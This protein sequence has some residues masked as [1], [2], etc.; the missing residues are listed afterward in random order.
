MREGF[1]Y[2]FSSVDPVGGAHIDPPSVA[3]YETLM[4]KGPDDAPL[5]GLAT[6]W[7]V[8]ADALTWR[9]ELRES[10]RFH[11]GAPCDAEAVVAALNG[12]RWGGDPDRQLWYWDPVD[13]VRVVG[14]ATVDITLHHPYARLPTLLWGTHTEIHNEQMRQRLGEDY[15][16]TVADGTG[17]YRMTSWS[18]DRLEAEL[19]DPDGRDRPA[20]ITWVS[21]L[22]E[23]SRVAA[24][25]SG[26]LSVLRCPPADVAEELDGH[27]WTYVQVP[28][29]SNLYISLNFRSQHLDFDR[30]EM[31]QAISRAI[32]R[33]RV[34]AEALGG[35]GAPTLGPVPPHNRFYRLDDPSTIAGARPDAA[36]AAL[37]ELG[38]PTGTDGVRSRDGVRLSFRC[39]TQEDVAFRAV[40][41]IVTENLRSV[42]IDVGFDYELPFEPFYAAAVKEQDAVMSKWLWPDAIEAAIGFSATWCDGNPNWQHADVPEVDGAYARWLR[43]ATDQEFDD[44]ARDVQ[45]TFAEHLPYV[46]LLSAVDTFLIRDDVAWFTPQAGMLYPEY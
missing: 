10:A 15:G 4:R 36:A 11:S 8:S 38:W 26:D 33:P 40:A 24:V 9:L 37:D 20:K 46:P 27:G 12:C 19:V 3:I 29:D 43:A 42:G 5:P 31:R 7:T 16:R 17:P 22:D 13:E 18:P 14:P 28:Q 45:V 30:V 41:A 32:D 1:E 44:A 25:R 39:L 34:V 2:R 21:L 35:L 6:S 23:A